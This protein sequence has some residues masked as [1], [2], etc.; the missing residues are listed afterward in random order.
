MVFKRIEDVANQL[1]PGHH[2]DRDDI[3]CPFDSP[4][5]VRRG[6]PEWIMEAD[7]GD[8][9][10]SPSTLFIVYDDLAGFAMAMGSGDPQ[11]LF[12]DLISGDERMLR[13]LLEKIDY[14]ILYLGLGFHRGLTLGQAGCP[15]KKQQRNEWLHLTSS[16][17]A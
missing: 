2:L 13:R 11:L 12:I 5:P 8:Y 17:A 14:A 9:A 1:G 10:F 4:V 6:I 3:P 7:R 16:G 15:D